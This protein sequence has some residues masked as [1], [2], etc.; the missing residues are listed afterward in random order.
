LL[1]QD[2]I[3]EA[4]LLRLS[5][6]E[7][8]SGQEKVAAAVQTHQEGVDDVHAIARD[9]PIGDV[10]GVLKR[11]LLSGQYDVT[12]Q[13]HLGMSQRRT[14]DGADHWHLDIQ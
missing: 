8:L 2:L 10:G 14:I 1:G 11:G 3:D 7:R 6:G 9:Q 13:R 5:G 4:E 12:Q